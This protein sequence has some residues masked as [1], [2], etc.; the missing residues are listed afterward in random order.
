MTRAEKIKYLKDIQNGPTGPQMRPVMIWAAD[1]P[2]GYYN[3]PVDGL[4]LMTRP[5][6]EV[7]YNPRKHYH[8]FAE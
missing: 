7:R 8:L 5:E 4:P 6:I 3:P 2:P 1:G